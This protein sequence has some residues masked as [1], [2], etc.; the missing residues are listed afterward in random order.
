VDATSIYWTDYLLGVVQK[1][2]GAIMTVP[3]DGGT[4]TL[5]K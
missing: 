4:P 1:A 2:A 5:R 3:I